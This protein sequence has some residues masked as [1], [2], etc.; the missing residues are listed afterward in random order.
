MWVKGEDNY[1]PVG[2]VVFLPIDGVAVLNGA[3]IRV[4]TDKM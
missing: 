1:A 2:R 4:F 3:Y